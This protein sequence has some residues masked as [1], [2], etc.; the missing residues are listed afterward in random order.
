MK[1]RLLLLLRLVQRAEELGQQGIIVRAVDEQ[2]PPHHNQ[3]GL[4]QD[5]R[6]VLQ[7]RAPVVVVFVASFLF[8]LVATQ[9][10]GAH[11]MKVKVF[12]AVVMAAEVAAP[13]AIGLA[14]ERLREQPSQAI[15]KRPL[16]G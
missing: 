13:L 2:N 3:N 1:Q 10:R 8:A 9:R 7:A 5:G 6:D 14:L 4:A 12:F 11:V 16:L 15:Q